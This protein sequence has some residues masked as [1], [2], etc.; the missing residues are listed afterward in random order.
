MLKI[1]LGDEAFTGPFW[2][3]ITNRPEPRTSCPTPGALA[4][5]SRPSKEV[6]RMNLNIF[7][8]TISISMARKTDEAVTWYPGAERTTM[9]RVIEENRRKASHFHL[10]V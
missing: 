1:G 6:S 10:M 2:Y 5:V 9:E 7:G 3:D 4:R 8:L